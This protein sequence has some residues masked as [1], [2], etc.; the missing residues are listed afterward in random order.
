MRGRILLVIATAVVASFTTPTASAQPSTECSAWRDCQRLAEAAADRGEYETFHDL[1][2]RAVQKGPRNDPAL[3]FLL[4]RAQSLSG[5]PHDAVVML[6]RIADLG[7]LAADALTNDDFR[8]ARQ[9]PAWADLEARVT[10]TAPSNAMLAPAPA[11]PPAAGN[12]TPAPAD[13]TIPTLVPRPAEAV[14]FPAVPFA[15]GGVAYDAV[16]QRFLLG[17]RH[18]R[19]V[20][21][22]G[23]GA[24]HSVDLVRAASGG[25]RDVAAIEI[26]ARRGDL[27]VA[28]AGEADGVGLLH[29]LQLI[30]GRTLKTYPVP[31]NGPAVS[32]AD[33]A[34]TRTGV[35]ILL[36]SR[37]PQLLTLRPGQDAVERVAHL[38]EADLT[39]V[40]VGDDEEVAYVAHRDG[41]SRVSIRTGS[42]AAVTLPKDAR[43]GRVEC[44]RWY[45][46]ALIAVE[47][48]QGARRVVRLALNDRGTAVTRETILAEGIPDGGRVVAATSG[49]D[50]V[51]VL[52]P[53]TGTAG[54]AS[55]IIVYRVHLR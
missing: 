37:G 10:V 34:V 51:Y 33:L 9:L 12:V 14:R 40:A 24:D 50:L 16:S 42:A 54:P 41:I 28:S 1:A 27:W 11:A 44:I 45:Q 20:I 5:R 39:S 3:M 55:D 36:D 29:K 46:R 8:R 32:P 21:V 30:S 19:K 4:A 35:V 7:A 15:V 48:V 38:S 17:D 49:D 43:L 26:D 47:Q 6:Q 13:T 18:G 23:Q 31:S 2:W 25:F 53:A 52:G 22:V